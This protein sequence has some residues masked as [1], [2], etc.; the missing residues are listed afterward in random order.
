ACVVEIVVLENRR[1][2]NALY[3]RLAVD[4][5]CAGVEHVAVCKNKTQRNQH[6][7]NYR[8]SR[9]PPRIG[10]DHGVRVNQTVVC[11]RITPMR[12]GVHTRTVWIDLSMSCVERVA[13]LAPP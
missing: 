4:D 9:A 3:R 5:V 6:G 1:I 11:E 8:C 13:K 10:S 2:D 7:W 12:D